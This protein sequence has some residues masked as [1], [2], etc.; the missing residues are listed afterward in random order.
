[1]HS[2]R[3]SPVLSQTRGFARLVAYQSGAPTHKV[4][5]FRSLLT[6]KKRDEII[7][8]E[9]SGYVYLNTELKCEYRHFQ[10]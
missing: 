10:K 9:W 4:I 7:F 1:M 3:E 2:Q 8:T 6:H 5:S